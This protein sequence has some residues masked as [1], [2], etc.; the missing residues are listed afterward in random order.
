VAL[1]LAGALIAT[2]VTLV[3]VVTGVISVTGGGEARSASR[4][5]LT[6][7]QVFEQSAA[8]VV[9]VRATF[10]ATD[11]GG[12][13][14]GIGSGFLV[15]HE[16]DIITN[17]HVVTS[18][19]R[20]A[21]AIVVVFRT[22]SGTDP[23]GAQ[24]SAELVGSDE[25]SDVA[26]LSID[27]DEAPS[28]D[29][30]PLGESESLRVGEPVTAI[31][32]P[33][34]LSFTVTSGI[35]SATDRNLRSPNGMVIPNGIQTDAAIN[36]GNSGGPLIDS[37]GKVIGVNTQIMTQSGGSQGLGFA[38]PIETAVRVVDQLKATGEVTYA[39]LG[40]SGHGLTAELAEVLG[41]GVDRGLLV[42]AVTPGSPAAVAGIR[43]GTEQALLQGQPFVV[44]GDVI[45]AVDGRS[46]ASTEDLA[47]EIAQREPGE[48]VTV[49]LVRGSQRLTVEVSLAARRT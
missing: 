47:A 13:G 27:P 5:T 28:L 2:L 40:A 48:T 14:S 46:I 10:A 49:D 41:I 34:G 23:A 31:G 38:V 26:L 37:A 24:V 39:Y 1:L 44:G 32:N 35:V 20:D 4:G 45:T 33:L 29:P 25:N 3:L 17:A 6:P 43:G 16:G 9:E 15:S 36:S 11:T 12:G 22:E 19:G 42:V 7:M 30:L 8:G 21:S 18:D